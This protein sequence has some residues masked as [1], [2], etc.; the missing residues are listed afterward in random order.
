[1]TKNTKHLNDKSKKK[2]IDIEEI[3]KKIQ[4]DRKKSIVSKKSI[5]TAIKKVTKNRK[6]K[7]KQ[8]KRLED[9]GDN[10]LSEKHLEEALRICSTAVDV[11]GIALCCIEH[12]LGAA[13]GEGRDRNPEALETIEIDI[14]E[15]ESRLLPVILLAVALGVLVLYLLVV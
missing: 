11:D 10:A 8:R 5:K 6:E 2:K 9:A 4:T 13:V 1:M 12:P 7:E 15:Q 3:A 14:P